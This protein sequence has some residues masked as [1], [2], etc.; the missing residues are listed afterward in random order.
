MNIATLP[1]TTFKHR[2]DADYIAA[3]NIDGEE[4]GWAYEVVTLPSGR[5][6]IEVFDADGF[7]LGLL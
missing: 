3:V 5:F 7:S 1:T 2:I 4:D 6:A